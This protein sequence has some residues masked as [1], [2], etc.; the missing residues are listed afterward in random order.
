MDVTV[1][2]K[3]NP[4]Y[5]DGVGTVTRG[6]RRRAVSRR[7]SPI[8]SYAAGESAELEPTLIA[9]LSVGLEVLGGRPRRQGAEGATGSIAPSERT[10]CELCC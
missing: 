2:D 3:V 7:R 10:S 6:G 9:D 4:L 8:D 5:T 1:N